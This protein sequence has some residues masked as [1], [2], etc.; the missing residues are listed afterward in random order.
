MWIFSAHHHDRIEH[1]LEQQLY[2]LKQILRVLNPPHFIITQI[3][4]DMATQQPVVGVKI[5]ATG[6]FQ[7]T[8]TDPSGNPITLPTGITPTWTS[9][10]TVNAPVV[11]SADGTTATVTV[12]T[13]APTTL[14]G[15]TFLLNITATLADGTVVNGAVAVPFLAATGV[16]SFVITQLS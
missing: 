4:D 13:T 5:G 14:V 15:T 6:T 1:L 7:E 12:P 11:A 8:Y 3:G 2:V 16:N 9:S 10:D